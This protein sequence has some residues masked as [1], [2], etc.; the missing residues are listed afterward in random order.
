[1]IKLTHVHVPGRKIRRLCSALGAD[2]FKLRNFEGANVIYRPLSSTTEVLI[3][4]VDN[5]DKDYKGEVVLYENGKEVSKKA[6]EGTEEDAVKA[7][8]EVVGA[9]EA[10][11]LARIPAHPG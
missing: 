3:F 7:L 1:M 5:I 4:G 9:S 2:L 11:S 6:F 10:P 8:E